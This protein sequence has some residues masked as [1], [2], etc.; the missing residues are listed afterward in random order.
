MNKNKIK[1]KKG[2]SH[3]VPRRKFA[4]Q[5]LRRTLNIAPTSHLK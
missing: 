5:A 1:K 2:A 4:R 3:P